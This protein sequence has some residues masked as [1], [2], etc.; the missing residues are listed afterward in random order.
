MS[1]LYKKL[2][3][4][5]AEPGQIKMSCSFLR[6]LIPVKDQKKLMLMQT[7]GPG[8]PWNIPCLCNKT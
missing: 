1:F 8:W 6:G 4:S 5:Q 7:Y 2:T 3:L